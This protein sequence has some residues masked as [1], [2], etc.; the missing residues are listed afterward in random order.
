MSSIMA[1]SNNQ[2]T[3]SPRKAPFSH[4]LAASG[5]V[6][7]VAVIDVWNHSRDGNRICVFLK[8]AFTL[9]STKTI[10]KVKKEKTFGGL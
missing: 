6:A 5:G 10:G 7:V 4:S 3:A 2:S 8:D 9:L 1:D